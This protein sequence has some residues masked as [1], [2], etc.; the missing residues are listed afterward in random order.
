MPPRE[1]GCLEARVDGRRTP[2]GGGGAPRNPSPLGAPLD[3]IEV[4]EAPAWM[5]VEGVRLLYALQHKLPQFYHNLGGRFNKAEFQRVCR[6]SG[7][8]HRATCFEGAID[9]IWRLLDPPS[10]G[11][12]EWQ[13]ARQVLKLGEMYKKYEITDRPF[14]YD[15]HLPSYYGNSPD[16]AHPKWQQ[17]LARRSHELV[18]IEEM[19]GAKVPEEGHSVFHRNKHRDA[20]QNALIESRASMDSRTVIPGV[21]DKQIWRQRNDANVDNDVFSS[22]SKAASRR[23]SSV[24]D[25][26]PPLSTPGAGEIF[27]PYFLAQRTPHYRESL[28]EAAM[29]QRHQRQM[30]NEGRGTPLETPIACKEHRGKTYGGGVLRDELRREQHRPQHK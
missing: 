14:D 29:Q 4:P 9:E 3:N 7:V 5:S 25:S 16:L 20:L 10:A 28:D 23:N 30:L 8:H 13:H 27:G 15:A 18:R 17:K 26:A 21:R 11:L 12:V 19:I 24:R 22:A 6:L 2:A 1:I